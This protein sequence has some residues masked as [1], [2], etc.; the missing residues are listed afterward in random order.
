LVSLTDLQVESITGFAEQDTITFKTVLIDRPGNQT[1]GSASVN[2]LVIDQT[3]P[4]LS[5]IHIESDNSDST[6]AKVGDQ[7]KVSFSADEIIN[8]PAVTISDN[9]AT[10][11]NTED[12]NWIATYIMTES[13]AEG[14]V[15]FQISSY[16]D[17]RG[18]P[19]DGT[20]S[21]SDGSQVIFDRTKPILDVVEFSTNNIWN[22]YWAKSGEQGTLTINASEGLLDLQYTLNS[23]SVTEN[24][25]VQVS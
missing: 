1:E 5:G 18:N 23:I 7:I 25:V 4:I 8:G 15:Q 22:Q 3:A 10:V 11:S 21:T 2:R 12:F 16:T 9:N 6:R 14:N 20:S 17:I 13:D 19:A 24:W